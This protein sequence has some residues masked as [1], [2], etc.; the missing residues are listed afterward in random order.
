MPKDADV[1]IAGSGAIGASAALSLAT[2]GM[3]VIVVEKEPGPALHQ[4]G[5]NSGVVHAGYQ[6]EPGSLKARFTQ[7]GAHRLI[8]YCRE[9]GVA[10]RRNGLLVVA[11]EERE[12]AGLETMLD[13]SDANDVAAERVGPEEMRE[14]EPNVGGVGGLHVPSY[15]SFDARGYVHALVGDAIGEG[16][17]FLFDTRVTGWESVEGK[18]RVETSKGILE[19]SVFVNAAGLF[20]DRLAGEV[21]GDLRVIPFRGYY[22]ELVTGRRGLVNGHVYPAPDPELP[23]LGVHFSPRVDGRV[24]VGPGAML[25]LGREAYSFWE[26]NVRDA[27]STFSWPGFYRLVMG[28]KIRSLIAREVKKSLSLRALASE[29]ASLVPGV[30]VG[31]L[32]RSYAGNRAQMVSRDGELVMDLVV[33]TRARSVHVLNAI[34]PGL[35]CSLPFGE[36]IADRAQ[37][38]A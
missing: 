29:A 12:L 16:S 10:V 22:A 7:E 36:H 27:W 23:F 26:G 13:R 5:R 1:I 15:A 38:L 20:A 31:D 6:Y 11:R 14:I 25:A 24:I 18:V 34:S 33:R 9:R 28:G 4:S 35:T 17:T 30:G 2:R 19:G 3:R 21:A 32:A 8:T 37:D